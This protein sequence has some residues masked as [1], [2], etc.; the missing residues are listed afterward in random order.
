M[1]IEVVGLKLYDLKELSRI[2]KVNR[3]TLRGY[4]EHG[5]LK[6]VKVGRS[7]RVNEEDLKE[8]LLIRGRGI[9]KVVG[10]ELKEVPKGHLGSIKEDLLTR[11]SLYGEFIKGKSRKG[12]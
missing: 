10:T 8:F 6:A 3:V 9:G 7:Y 1:P 5:R 2:L 4:I 11:E 12:N